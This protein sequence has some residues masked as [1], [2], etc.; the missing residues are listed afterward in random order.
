[1]SATWQEGLMLLHERG[2]SGELVDEAC[3]ALLEACSEGELVGRDVVGLELAET[4]RVLEQAI[5]QEESAALCRAA[6][7]HDRADHEGD[8]MR[9]ALRDLDAFAAGFPGK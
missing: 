4:R 6:E 8:S 9:E 5:S 1:M 7:V 2:W 3:T